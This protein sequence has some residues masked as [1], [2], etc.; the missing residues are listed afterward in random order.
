LDDTLHD[1]LMVAR[2]MELRQNWP[3]WPRNSWRA[4][5]SISAKRQ[6]ATVALA[7]PLV[8]VYHPVVG[9]TRV[10]KAY[11]DAYELSGFRYATKAQV[12]R[13]YEEHGLPPPRRPVA[14]QPAHH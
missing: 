2:Q 4:A 1:W 3:V 6:D 9:V 7:G 14:R 12:K 10:P 13:W 11:M 8:F 5:P